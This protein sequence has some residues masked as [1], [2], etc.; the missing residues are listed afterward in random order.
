VEQLLEPGE[1]GPIREH[2]R[3]HLRAVDLAV[4][5]QHVAAEAVDDRL[6]DLGIL[7]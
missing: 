2:D 6:L 1:L 5:T 4:G 7:A 3:A